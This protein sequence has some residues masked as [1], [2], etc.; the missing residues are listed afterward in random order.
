MIETAISDAVKS[1]HKLT[2]ARST[3]DFVKQVFEDSAVANLLVCLSRLPVFD[4]AFSEALSHDLVTLAV[5]KKLKFYTNLPVGQTVYLL[6]QLL[7]RYEA[8]KDMAPSENWRHALHHLTA[9][10]PELAKTRFKE[11]LE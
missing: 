6:D 1:L 3:Q 9:H 7:Q 11:Y 2:V 8:A 10:N 4:K 5:A